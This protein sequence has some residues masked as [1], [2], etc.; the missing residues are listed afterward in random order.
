[1]AQCVKPLPVAPAYHM[2]PAAL[3]LF[4]FLANVPGKAVG[5]LGS[6]ILIADPN[7]ASV[8][9]WTTPPGSQS[10]DGRY[11]YFSISVILP[12]KSLSLEEEEKM[13]LFMCNEEHFISQFI[14]Q[15]PLTTKLWTQNS[16]HTKLYQRDE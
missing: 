8:S 5:C 3:P 7:A 11:L 16:N 10:V 9:C 14:A 2:G 4:Q 1:M 12:F 15:I 6:C 13:M